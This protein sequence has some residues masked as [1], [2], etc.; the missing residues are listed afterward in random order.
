MTSP[1]PNGA[2]RSISIPDPVL[3]RD[4]ADALEMKWYLVIRDLMEMNI[5][6]TQSMEIDFATASSLCS[7]YGVAAH[8]II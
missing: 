8:K 7:R 2:S 4:L 3:V 6:A 1:D 5:F